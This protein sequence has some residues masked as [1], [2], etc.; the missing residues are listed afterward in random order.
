MARNY[1]A[2]Y[3]RRKTLGAERGLSTP[4]L[5]GH[6]RRSELPVRHLKH[7]GVLETS[8]ADTLNRYYAAVGNVERGDSLSRAA[9]KAGISPATVRRMDEDR[10][11]LGKTYKPGPTGASR[12][13]GW[14][15]QRSATFPVLTN[16]GD[17]QSNVQFDARNASLMGEYWNAV[18]KAQ[19]GG[20]DADLRAM[21]RVEI[22][23]IDGNRYRLLTDISDINNFFS[24][25][26]EEELEEF[27]RRFESEKVPVRRAA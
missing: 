5:R 4:Q 3:Q 22:R 23:D 24:E 15:V 19:N 25:M 20:S 21:N 11:L 17:Y 9:K 2:E 12:F 7:T 6:A 8:R 26:T 1:H 16:D 14:G 18:A 10:E 27:D 13:F